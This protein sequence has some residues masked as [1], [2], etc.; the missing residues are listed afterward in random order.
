MSAND[1]E[2][3][4]KE[5]LLSKVEDQK[6]E[7]KETIEKQAEKINRQIGLSEADKDLDNAA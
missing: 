6:A 2:K 5:A 4:L 3:N 7:D 1:T